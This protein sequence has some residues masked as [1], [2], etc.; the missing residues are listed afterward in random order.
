MQHIQGISGNQL[1]LY[2][3]ENTILSY[4]RLRLT[5]V[6]LINFIIVVFGDF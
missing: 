6:Y 4:K 1:Q 3:L 2:S 5:K